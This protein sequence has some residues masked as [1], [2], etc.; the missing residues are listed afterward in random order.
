MMHLRSSQV[1]RWNWSSVCASTARSTSVRWKGGFSLSGTLPIV[2][3]LPPLRSRIRDWTCARL[4][5]FLTTVDIYLTSP[6]IPWS[7]DE[8]SDGVPS[9]SISS[10]AFPPESIASS[11]LVQPFSRTVNSELFI[12]P[13]RVPLLH[14]GTWTAFC[15]ASRF[16]R[17]DRARL[18]SKT[19]MA[20]AHQVRPGSILSSQYIHGVYIPSALLIVGTAIV[21]MEWVIYAVALAAL[22]GAWKVYNNRMSAA[23]KRDNHHWFQ[24]TGRDG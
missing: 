8:R 12:S 3:G 13:H 16:L 15:K 18:H 10:S 9:L 5:A 20:S 22:L 4:F 17:L 7:G 19:R 11:E 14:T 21:K 24:L 6:S 23:C 1:W 2:A